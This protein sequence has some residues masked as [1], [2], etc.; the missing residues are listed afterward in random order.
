MVNSPTSTVLVAVLGHEA[1]AG[2]EHAADGAAGEARAVELDGAGHAG[3]EPEDRLGQ[4]GLAVALHARDGEDL[5]RVH[6]EAHAVDDDL[7]GRVDHGEVAHH[8]RGV[9]G[10]RG[11]L[12]HGERH[13]PADHEGRELRVAGGGLGL[14]DHLAEPDHRDAVRDLAHL[15]QLVGDEDDARAGVP[16]LL[17]D[18]HELVGLLRREHGGRLVEH[19]HLRVARQGLDDL[20]ALLDADGQVGDERVRIDVEA[21]AGGDRAPSRGRRPGRAGRRAS[22]PRA[23]A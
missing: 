23:R 18:D 2:V 7:A 11:L 13:A 21:E 9:A 3:L 12:L 6:L 17:H 15:P 16:E 19:E 1:D 4:L 14:A 8:E 20:D 5:P 22:S 10:R